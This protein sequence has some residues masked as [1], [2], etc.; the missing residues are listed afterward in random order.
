MQSLVLNL[1]AVC[2]GAAVSLLAL[3]SSIQARIHTTVMPPPGSAA[4]A[5]IAAG[6]YTYN[7]SQ[8]AVCAIWL[9]ANIWLANVVR[10]KMPSFNLPVIIYN[11]LVNISATYGPF[12][13]TTAAAEAFVKELL[14]AMLVALALGTKLAAT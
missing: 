14:T 6:A 7:S 8:S 4:A 13:T 3:W 2:I 10:A 12:M 11:I 9:F 5:A 1:L